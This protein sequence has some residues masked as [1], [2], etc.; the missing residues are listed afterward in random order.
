M[1][2]ASN[3]SNDSV[4]LKFKLPPGITSAT[5]LQIVITTSLGEAITDAEPAISIEGSNYSTL[6][7]SMRFSVAQGKRRV[8]LRIRFKRII[9]GNSN[10]VVSVVP[11]TNKA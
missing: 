8:N 2:T 7:A 1:A 11:I 5:D 6:N 9:E 10:V 3:P 4:E